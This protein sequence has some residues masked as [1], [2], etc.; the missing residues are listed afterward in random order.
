V[1]YNNNNKKKGY[2]DNKNENNGRS[3][4]LSKSRALLSLFF[5]FVSLSA[6]PTSVDRV[7]GKLLYYYLLLPLFLLLLLLLLLLVGLSA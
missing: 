5:L 1:T 4:K 7:R 2:H 3:W 6:E